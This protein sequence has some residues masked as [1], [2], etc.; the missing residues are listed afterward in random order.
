MIDPKLLEILV[1]PACHGELTAGDE[2]LRCEACGNAYPIQGSIPLMTI[3]S[4]NDGFGHDLYHAQLEG[5]FF[6]KVFHSNRIDTLM[7]LI[8]SELGIEL[9]SR[10]LDVG[11]NTGPMLVPLRRA[12]YQVAGIDISAHDVH[13]A[14]RYLDE[15]GLSSGLLAVADGTQLPFRNGSFN[16]ILLVDV[17]EHTDHAERIVA[18]TRRLLAPG[19]A[20]VATVPWGY[21]P[22]VRYDW[23]RKALSSRKTIDEH[24]DAPFTLKMLQSLFPDFEP[25]LFRLVFHWVCILGVYRMP[26]RAEVDPDA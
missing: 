25:V 5:N 3:G 23:I 2:A 19:G 8:T 17:L 21:H 12:G 16:L 20:V 26:A 11:C 6:E 22:F 24:P 18:E 13:Q 14:E 10:A 15:A 7:R 4:S 1:C 9:G